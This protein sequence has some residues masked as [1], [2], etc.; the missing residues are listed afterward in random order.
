[1]AMPASSKL[2][3]RNAGIPSRLPK[4][5]IE[6]FDDGTAL[7]KPHKRV[8]LDGKTLDDRIQDHFLKL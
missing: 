7:L 5:R 3:S 6:P 8:V 1:M 4:R 2:I